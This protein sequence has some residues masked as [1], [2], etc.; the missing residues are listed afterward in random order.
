LSHRI[1]AKSVLLG[2]V[3][4]STAVL[5]ASTPVSAACDPSAANNVAATCTGTT[6]NQGT[7]APGTSA[8]T[9]GYGDIA[10]TNLG[11]TVVT[12]ATVTGTN[13]GISADSA[14]ISNSGSIETIVGGGF[15]TGVLTANDVTIVNTG[16]I[17]GGN[18]AISSTLGAVNLINSGT[19]TGGPGGG[20]INAQTDATVT[21]YGYIL[22][23]TRGPNG[24]SVSTGT[25]TVI[26][27]GMISAGN[28]SVQSFSGNVDVINHGTLLQ[29][30]F[31]GTGAIVV[32]HGSIVSQDTGVAG[33]TVNVTNTSTIVG[34]GFAG[35]FATTTA[36]VNNSGT[37]SGRT[38]ILADTGNVTNSGTIIGTAGPAIQFAGN[39][40]TL[41]LL[42]GSNIQGAIDLG[43]GVNTL[44]VG[45][46]LSIANTFTGAA[47][48]IGTTYGAPF[49]VSGNQ[50]AVL[51]PTSIAAQTNGF[52]DLTNG[53][54]SSVQNWL[55]G[56]RNGGVVGVTQGPGSLI[57]SGYDT[58]RQQLWAQVFGVRR[59]SDRSQPILE[60]ETRV[61]G[62]VT[63][64]DRQFSHH[65][66]AGIFIGGAWGD[67]D[68]ELNTQEA[69]TDSFFGGLYASRGAGPWKFDAAITAG[70]SDNDTSREVAN[71]LAPTGLQT[72]RADFESI[73]VSPEVTITRAVWA[74]PVRFEP[75]LNLRYA[76]LFQDGY[77]EQGAADN[78]NLGARDVHLLQARAQIALPYEHETMHG[79]LTAV[80]LH[81]GLQGRTNLGDSGVNAVLLGQTIS[82]DPSDDDE[83]GGL[84]GG[85]TFS[86]TT[87]RGL[88][89]QASAEGLAE[90]ND[91]IQVTGH[92]GA[93]ITF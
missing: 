52:Y 11:V 47:P 12:G 7:G 83:V 59:N 40:D 62:V 93:K 87:P 86:H 42:A 79:G 50:V 1:A 14:T 49:A 77:R 75:G 82:F 46:G 26:N 69:E 84:Y 48:V 37:I 2:T 92:A 44:N 30:V 17:S 68:H 60:T 13:S 31:A 6:T 27:Y 81:I 24:V 33:N 8:F 21:N 4:L 73:F 56:S 43:G 5:F 34:S 28:S 39:P 32:N 35:V 58:T 57:D 78:L 16:S 67:L 70:W 9:V 22:G 66:R 25:A 20:A 51:D 88:T 64:L 23:G 90:T 38:G 85:A 76:G 80:A 45:N 15:L 55:N 41:T 10:L 72:A 61:G 89:L 29:G 63:G 54:L 65:A 36:T 91:S 71:N 18:S 53:I 74:G 3:M 19:I